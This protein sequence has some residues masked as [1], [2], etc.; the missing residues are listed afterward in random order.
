MLK[1]YLSQPAKLSLLV[2]SLLFILP[3]LPN[4]HFAPIS[5]FVSQALAGFVGLLASVY[6]LS[7]SRWQSIH[8]PHIAFVFLGLAVILAMQWL[9]GMLYSAQFAL[10]VLAYLLWAMVLCVFGSQI[11]LAL[12]WSSLVPTLAWASIL[13]ALLNLLWI[14]VQHRYPAMALYYVPATELALNMSLALVSTLYLYAKQKIKLSFSLILIVAF[15]VTLIFSKLYIGAVLVLLIGV[16]AL[17][18][19]ALAVGQH[20]TSL[21][22]RRIIRLGVALPVVYVLAYV[23][24]HYLPT[25]AQHAPAALC[26]ALTQQ[27]SEVWAIWQKTWSFA[28]HAWYL[29]T[30]LGQLPWVSFNAIEHPIPHGTAGVIENTHSLWLQLFAEMGVGAVVLVLVGGFSWLKAFDSKNL[31]AETWWV[32]SALGLILALSFISSVWMLSYILGISAFLLGAGERQNKILRL[33]KLGVSLTL[34]FL[35]IGTGVL[36]TS[37]MA[38][39]KLARIVPLA[40]LEKPSSA[41]QMQID[42]ALQWVGDYSLLSPYT[43]PIYAETL[44]L[45]PAAIDIKVWLSASAQHWMPSRKLAYRHVLLLK[46]QGKDELAVQY[47]RRS[48]FAYPG[49]FESELEAMPFAYWQDY[50]DVLSIA[51]PIKSKS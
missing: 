19:Q 39:Y 25:G 14:A 1:K 40:K 51:S 34:L 16:L 3:F 9:L 18:Q 50:L 30:G 48:L 49:K 42:N 15:L 23:V 47:L 10:T 44:T 33:P 31:S 43:M 27:W 36:L 24:L 2:I 41:Q 11:K 12:P 45:D 17:G 21:A 32:V 4:A 28:V 46:L 35:L 5:S 29:G 6:L 20:S 26:S 37:S 8:I 38:Y 13:A 22:S 7:K